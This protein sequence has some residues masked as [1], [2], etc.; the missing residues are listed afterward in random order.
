MW[1]PSLALFSHS[2]SWNSLIFVFCFVFIV[3]A[4]AFDSIVRDAFSM[5]L[6]ACVCVCVRCSMSTL[7]S[8][9]HAMQCHDRTFSAPK[10][11]KR[12]QKEMKQ[13]SSPKWDLFPLAGEKMNVIS[14]CAGVADDLTVY[15]RIIFLT[16]YRSI[17]LHVCECLR[18]SVCEWC[19]LR[20]LRCRSFIRITL[21]ACK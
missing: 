14:I 16:H 11:K 7:S 10:S 21:S 5:F 19:T 9:K 20:P 18:A 13:T 4:V 15:F 2:I 8:W 17:L 6:N 1:Y 12:K 3:I